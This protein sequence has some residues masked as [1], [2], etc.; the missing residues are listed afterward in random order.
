MVKKKKPAKKTIKKK[1]K[2]ISIRLGSQKKKTVKKPT[3]KAAKKKVKKPSLPLTSQKKKSKSKHPL[4]KTAKKRE[5]N[6]TAKG[7]KR[8]LATRM[9]QLA[10]N[11]VAYQMLLSHLLR[12][13]TGEPI[14]DGASLDEMSERLRMV[15]KNLLSE[16]AHHPVMAQKISSAYQQTEQ[17]WKAHQSMSPDDP[18]FERIRLEA[19]EASLKSKE[20]CAAMSDLVAALRYVQ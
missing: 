8:D 4:S 3:K 10:S 16:L 11:M 2:K 6:K 9:L 12:P 15:R 14:A 19:K 7:E 17:L 20:A 13:I 5:T 1:V 18:D